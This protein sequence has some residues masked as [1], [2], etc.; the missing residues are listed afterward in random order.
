MLILILMLI[1][2]YFSSL[3]VQS[4]WP[5]I[6]FYVSDS[7]FNMWKLC[8]LYG[9]CRRLCRLTNYFV[10][11]KFI[12]STLL[13]RIKNIFDFNLLLLLLCIFALPLE[14]SGFLQIIILQLRSLVHGSKPSLSF[15]LIELKFISWCLKFGALSEGEKKV[16]KTFSISAEWAC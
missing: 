1:L 12:L 11:N 7:F 10:T 6:T 9:T 16:L 14:N 5:D 8:L 2:I 4:F 3:M 15:F 13:V